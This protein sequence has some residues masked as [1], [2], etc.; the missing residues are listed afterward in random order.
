VHAWMP[1]RQSWFPYGRN[2]RERIV[3]VVRVVFATKWKHEEKSCRDTLVTVHDTSCNSVVEI[4][5]NSISTTVATGYKP[6]CRDGY[7]S[8]E[9]ENRQR[10][11]SFATISGGGGGPFGHVRDVYDHMEP[12]FRKMTHLCW[13]IKKMRSNRY[14]CTAT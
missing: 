11:N 5:L 13:K 7:V 3:T 12:G 9:T 4:G 6:A 10:G 1:L 8:M 2:C 14:H